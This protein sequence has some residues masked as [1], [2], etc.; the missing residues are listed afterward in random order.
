MYSVISQISAR[1]FFSESCDS[2]VETGD[3]GFTW[4]EQKTSLVDTDN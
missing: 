2:P 1:D 3:G 4:S